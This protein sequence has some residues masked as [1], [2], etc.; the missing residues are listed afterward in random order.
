[1][2]T[3]RSFFA[4]IAILILGACG[5]GGGGDGG[6]SGG[7]GGAAPGTAPTVSLGYG[8]KQLQFSWGAVSDATYYKLLE[9]PDGVSGYAQVGAN[10][11]ANSVTH[12]IAL[13]ARINATYIV[14]ACNAGGCTDSA[15]VSMAENLVPAM[16]Y[17]KASNP[18]ASDYFGHAVALSAD[19]TTLAVGAYGE[20]SNATGINGDQT[21]DSASGS[22]AVYVFT[23]SGG[24]WSQQAYVKASNTDAGDYFGGTVALS[25]DGNMLAVGA[26]GEDSNATG[27][28]GD[29][30]N[31]S[32][33]GSGAV[34]VFTRS[35]ATWSQQAYVKASNAEAGDNF[36]GALALSANGTVLAVGAK[37]ESSNATG[38]NGDQTDNSASASG[39][40]YI[41]SR[42]GTTWSQ[43]AYVKGSNTEAVDYFGWAVALSS[44]GYTLA[45]GARNE[46]SNASG[47]GGD[48]TNDSISGSGAVYVFSRSGTAWSQQ[49]YVK[50]SNP[51]AGDFFGDAV[52]LSSDGN[53]LAVGAEWESSN[54]TGINGD[55][56]DNS[57]S[58]FGA[59]YVFTRSGTAW[60]QQ[61]YVKASNSGAGDEFGISLALSS[62][63]NTLAVGALMESSNDTGINVDQVD[64]SATGSG[65][66]YVFTRSGTAWSQQAYVK[67]SN[68]GGFDLFSSGLALSSDGNTLV[69]GA[70]WESSNATGINGDQSNNSLGNVGTVYL[71]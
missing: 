10:I 24:T 56:T 8:I 31:N 65:A 44:D 23:R 6:S 67:A 5:G 53:T 27:I 4:V 35:G 1:M 36:G 40:V 46:S 39:A 59:V 51:G 37:N 15:P 50:A 18:G 26:I 45:V 49:A 7:G 66:V 71:Y 43:R 57:A 64:N 34:Y 58:G 21:N 42:A 55:Q 32:A 52:A 61:A 29:Q 48:Q 19:G 17:F 69:V 30:T 2:K 33:S 9:N 13:Y 68:T 70:E 54:A 14:E 60:S 47:I 11:T 25:S 22:G 63:G 62:D 3:I 41:L 28:N 20:D 12:D 16:G 38:I